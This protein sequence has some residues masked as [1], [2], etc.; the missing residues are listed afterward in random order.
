MGNLNQAVNENIFK[1]IRS[2]IFIG[3]SIY[4]FNASNNMFFYG[5]KVR[6]TAY[7]GDAYTGIQNAA[8]A[9]ARNINMLGD[10]IS[11]AASSFF[12]I[13]GI[14]L[15]AI[16]IIGLIEAIVNIKHLNNSKYE[17]NKIERNGSELE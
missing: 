8:A 3:I 1:L 16:G 9:T 17:L 7:G 12:I 6:D 10:L 14:I 13:V 4:G 5:E 11:K 2:I 15:I